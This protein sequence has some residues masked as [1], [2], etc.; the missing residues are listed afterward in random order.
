M[1]SICIY[2]SNVAGCIT[3]NFPGPPP[4]NRSRRLC[5]THYHAGDV[6][7]QHGQRVQIVAFDGRRYVAHN[8]AK[9]CH[10]V[11]L[12]PH[13]RDGSRGDYRHC[14]RPGKIDARART[15]DY[16]FFSH[17]PS[18][19]CDTAAFVGERSSRHGAGQFRDFWCVD[20]SPAAT[21]TDCRGCCSRRQDFYPGSKAPESVN[22]TQAVHGSAARPL[23]R[24]IPRISRAKR[25]GDCPALHSVHKGG[26]HVQARIAAVSVPAGS[27][28]VAAGSNVR[29]VRW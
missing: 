8:G 3:R 22:D 20:F 5:S 29:G 13:L 9:M 11:S 24:A 21:A 1:K 27:A 19:L 7:H 14:Y 16:T 25:K 15:G 23:Y 26:I 12:P 10:C 2:Y 28:D 4:G 18:L 17:Q 6:Y